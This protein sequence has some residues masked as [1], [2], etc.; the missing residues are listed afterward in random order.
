M[1]LFSTYK[2]GSLELKNRVVMAP[3][4]RNRALGNIPSDLMAKYYGQRATAGLLITEGTAPSANGLGYARIPGLYS[5]AQVEGWKL[6]TQAVH[7]KGGRIF[8]QLMH[9]GRVGHPLNMEEGAEIVAPSPLANPGE[10]YTDQEGMQPHPVPREMTKA[11]IDQAIAEF[12]NAAKNAIAAGFDGVEIHAANGYLVEQFIN[13]GTNQ[14]QDEYGGGIENR[15]RFVVEVAQAISAEIGGERTGIRLSPYGVFNGT[16]IYDELDATYA[17]L[18]EELNNIGVVYIHIV[19]HEAM[20]APAVPE[21]VREAIRGAY[22]GTIILSGGYEKARAESDLEAG[23]GHLVAF[24]RPL[25]ANPDLVHR[26]EHD[27][28]LNQ[29]DFGTF[30][31]PGP[32]GYTD[33]PISDQ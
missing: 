14:R 16:A 9:T 12:V 29:P 26:M 30:Y 15:I 19:N 13:P 23:K 5:A 3:M 20:G 27:L 18:A 17:K 32:Q 24:G 8:A 4:T 22:S 28:E 2:L 31:T 10:M 6:V 1:Q 33:Y 21:S 11:D 7:D 25:L